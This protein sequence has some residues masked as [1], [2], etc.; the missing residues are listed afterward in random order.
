MRDAKNRI[1]NAGAVFLRHNKV[2]AAKNMKTRT[3]LRLFSVGVE[4]VTLWLRDMKSDKDSAAV[5]TVLLCSSENSC[6]KEIL[7]IS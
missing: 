2:W 5:K 6:L 7:K 1:T 4:T 3:K